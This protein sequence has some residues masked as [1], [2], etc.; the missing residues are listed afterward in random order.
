MGEYIKILIKYRSIILAFDIHRKQTLHSHKAL[1]NAHGILK[2]VIC[3]FSPLCHFHLTYQLVS[4]K[5]VI[6][7]K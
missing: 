5:N 2:K 3:W 7:K 6:I 4:T 1:S